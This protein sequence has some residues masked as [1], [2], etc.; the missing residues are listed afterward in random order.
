MDE[1]IKQTV[2]KLRKEQ[3]KSESMFWQAVRNRKLKGKKFLRQHP[4]CFE[5]DGRTRFFIEDFYCHEKRF[6]VEI[7]GKIH[8]K[9]KDYDALRTHIIN[10]LGMKVIR[11]KNEEIE[12]NLEAVLECI[13]GHL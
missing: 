8:L 5:I 3:T 6:V 2:R 1:R 12:R 11:F 10:V 7:D 9:Q 13:G 4:I